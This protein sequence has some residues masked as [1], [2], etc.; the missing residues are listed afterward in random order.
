MPYLGNQPA[1][2]AVVVGADAVGTAEIEDLSVDTADIN[3]NAVTT[4]KMASLARGKIIVGNASGDPAALAAGSN[5]QV[6]KMDGSGDIVWG[7]DSGGAAL[8]G[9]TDNQV[10]T[11]TGADAI[12][13]ESGLTFASNVL[14]VTG[15]IVPS[16]STRD[17]GTSGNPW[18]NV[19]TSDI[20]LDN[21]RKRNGNEVDG[22]SGIW[23]IQEGADDL[24]LINRKTGKKFK[25][26]LQEID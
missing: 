10:V 9:S 7:T 3:N 25:F 20:H 14:T 8:T 2:V 13:G 11:V 5:G 22:T 23:T 17:L 16:G 18:Q 15:N 26:Q 12:A 21:T 19:Y 24:F 1:D 4:D 6:L